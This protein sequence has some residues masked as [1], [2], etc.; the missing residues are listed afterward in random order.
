MLAGIAGIMAGVT[1]D[2]VTTADT[3]WTLPGSASED[4]G[5]SNEDNIT[6]RDGTDAVYTNLGAASSTSDI[7]G[8]NYGFSLPDGA[9]VLGVEARV[10]CYKDDDAGSEREVWL[11]TIQLEDNTGDLGNDLG[12]SDP[13]LTGSYQELTFGGSSDLWGASLTKAIVEKTS[14]G[15]KVNFQS[16]SGSGTP[17]VHVDSV[18]LKVHYEYTP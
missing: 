15:V 9:T 8:S 7:H 14:F 6:A 16:F 2:S 5:W 13:E 17:D 4:G 10:R 12:T 11:D 3:G 1:A 18:E